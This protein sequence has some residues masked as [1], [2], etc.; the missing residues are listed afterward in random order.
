MEIYN[1]NY[2]FPIL[3][4]T[5]TQQF[6]ENKGFFSLLDKNIR[7]RIYNCV[8]IDDNIALSLASKSM[9]L[10][11]RLWFKMYL[12]LGLPT[13]NQCEINKSSECYI[14]K[15]KSKKHLFTSTW[16]GLRLNANMRENILL[17]ACR[18]RNENDNISEPYTQIP[19]ALQKPQASQISPTPT[20]ITPTQILPTPTQTSLT[21]TPT[22]ASLTPQT[23]KESQTPQI[24]TWCVDDFDNS[25]KENKNIYSF[26]LKPEE[27]Q[28]SG[29]Y[30]W[31]RIDN[32]HLDFIQLYKCWKC[33][34]LPLCV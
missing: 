4:D 27:Y 2:T 3:F 26:A 1:E 22:Q 16:D 23:P 30:N 6:K 18:S 5:Q 12:P 19:K 15:T 33:Y 34:F 31:S 9:Y 28:P 25:I 14:C 11:T 21:P 8:T 10:D 32:F 13:Y 20:Q 17:Y 7:Y 24:G 29:H